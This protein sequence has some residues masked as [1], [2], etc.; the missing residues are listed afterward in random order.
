MKSR[1]SALNRTA[2]ILSVTFLLTCALVI[3]SVAQDAAPASDLDRMRSDIEALKKGQDSIQKSLEEIKVLLRQNAAAAAK[4]A[5][6]QQAV[7]NVTL[8]LK[9]HQIKG[10]PEAKLTLV[11]FSDYQCPYC[12]RHTRDTY[13]SIEKDFIATGKVRYAM[14]DLPLRNHPFAF[15]A[16]EAATCAGDQGKFWEMHHL[17][18]DNQNALNPET[19]PT[20]A[21]QLGLDRNQF[22]ACMTEGRQQSV[23]AD[24]QQ[25]TRAGI[26]AT[27]TFLVGWL[28]ADNQLKPV[29]MIRGAQSYVNFAQLL[30]RLL[31][32][33]PP[34]AGK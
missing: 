21:D 25:A 15:R 32:Q 26:S 16:A 13:P 14:V 28:T 29:E 10:A 19:L 20:Y 5:A 18:F 7:P 24:M 33:G 34:A 8:D 1:P 11:E 9:S 17:L 4:P 3:P 27:P 31:E 23:N 2:E 6:A 30:T 22:D 12:A